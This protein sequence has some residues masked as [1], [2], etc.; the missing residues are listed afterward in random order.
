[1]SN[2]RPEQRPG[3]LAA[4]ARPRIP[5]PKAEDLASLETRAAAFVFDIALI[6]VLFGGVL[7]VVYFIGLWAWRGQ[8]VGQ[9]LLGIKVVPAAAERM[10]LR[11]ATMRLVGYVVCIVTLGAG[12]VAAAFDPNRQG[13]HDRI[14]ATYV[15]RSRRW[16]R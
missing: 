16:G 6:L 14:G 11:I 8:S 2:E 13:W 4:R 9:M 5:P 7:V 12:F 15:V 1:M 3:N 10:D